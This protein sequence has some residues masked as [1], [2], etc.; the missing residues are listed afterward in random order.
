MKKLIVALLILASGSLFAQQD[1][2]FSQYMFNKLAVNPGYAGSR[3]TLSADLLNRW[4]WVGISGAPNTLSASIHSPL[5]NQHLG[6]GFTYYRDHLGP[7]VNQGALAAFAYRIVFPKGKLSFG[8]QAGIKHLGIDWNDSDIDPISIQD[9]LILSQVNQKAVMDANFGVYYY[10]DNFY[11]GISSKQLL[12]NQQAI[13]EVEGKSEFTKLWRHFYGMAG[14]AFPITE[15]LV[16]RPSML[17]KYVQ[18]APPQMDLNLSFLF[19]N[20]FWTGASYRTEKAVSLLTEIR[21][22]PNVRIGYSYDIWLNELRAYNKGSHEIRI[23]FDLNKQKR[24]LT[25]RYF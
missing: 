19:G 8:I 10:S 22:T 2:L 15:D 4:Q 23:G 12:Q 6:I 5:R 17:V 14:V 21:I 3:E 20:S 25:P 9:P 1:P 11:V 13:V 16:F 7:M 24:M 18:H